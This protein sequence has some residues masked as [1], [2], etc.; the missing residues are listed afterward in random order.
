MA[1]P[2]RKLNF[3][4]SLLSAPTEEDNHGEVEEERP[5]TSAAIPTSINPDAGR[6]RC[7]SDVSCCARSHLGGR[8]KPCAPFPGASPQADLHALADWLKSVGVK[9]VAME[10]TGV[11]WIPTFGILE[12]RGD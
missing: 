11:Y 7:W 12:E 8:T 6:P 10:S 9:S 1:I 4:P 3:A 5:L 2:F